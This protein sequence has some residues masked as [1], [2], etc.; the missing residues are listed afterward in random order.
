MEEK[1]ETE[2]AP[3]SQSVFRWNYFVKEGLG[4]TVV[5]IFGLFIVAV[6]LIIGIFLF[7][8]GSK[9]FTTYHHSVFEF[10]FSSKWKPADSFTGGGQ[11]GAAI[12]IVGSLSTCSL[13]LAIATPFSLASAIF[14]TQIS[15][16]LGK[17][18]LQ[19]AIEI[20]V[21]IPSVVY[22]WVGLTLLVPFI[23]NLFHTQYGYG[24]LSAGIVL[25]LMIFPTITSVASDAIRHVP[26]AY[27]EASYGLGSTRWQSITRVV[28]PSAVPGILTGVILGLA[29]AFGEALA[30]AM[31][32]GKMLTFPKDLFSPT[33]NLTAAIAAS[34]GDT[35]Q[36]GEYNSAL[37]TMGLLLLLISF[38]C[39]LI[40]RIIGRKGERNE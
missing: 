6:T 40:V 33:N 15:P 23:K 13:A 26:G 27:Q 34:M 35:A 20:F 31:V 7:V 5:T 1:H 25:A 2:T 17:R 39:I 21:G 9:T 36:G 16:K 11:V 32:I 37:W 12:F 30:V 3:R 10:L 24:V 8:N 29:R 38:A 19:P 18:F 14:M 4:R 22:G 28:L